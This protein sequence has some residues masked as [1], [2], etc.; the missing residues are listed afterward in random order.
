MQSNISY[1]R[2]EKATDSLLKNES[3]DYKNIQNYRY[4]SCFDSIV[5]FCGYWNHFSICANSRENYA[6]SGRGDQQEPQC[7]VVD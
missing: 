5:A 7:R 1:F 6:K 3:K 2:T 4:Y